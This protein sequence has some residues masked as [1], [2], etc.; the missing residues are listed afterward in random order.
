MYPGWYSGRTVHIHVRVS[1]GGSVVH[2]GQLFFPESLTDA[3][4]RRAPY[5]RRPSRDTRNATDSI[6]RN[7][8]E[9][10]D[11]QADEERN[12]LRRPHHHG[13]QPLVAAIELAAARRNPPRRGRRRSTSAGATE[14][15][16]TGERPA[17]LAPSGRAS[18]GERLPAMDGEPQYV[19]T[20]R[21]P[22]PAE[23]GALV[24]EAHRRFG[25]V[26]DGAP[27]DVYPALARVP[28]RAS[29]SA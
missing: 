17:R 21:L 5:N 19:S 25:P 24:D 11:A 3:V 2:T 26:T 20:G 18:A 23:V 10:L 29:A 7:G 9:P 15:A 13:S 8:G 6:F 12:R 4:Y 16:V 14:P 27:S 22:A 28:P 1:M